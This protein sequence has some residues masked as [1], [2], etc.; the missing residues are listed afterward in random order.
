MNAT[1]KSAKELER[2]EKFRCMSAALDEAEKGV[3]H[4]R[5][6][7]PVGAVVVKNGRIIGRGYHAHCGEDHAEV[8]ALKSCK[9]SPKGATVYV[10]LEPCS[11]PGRV[12]ACTDALIAAGVKRVEWLCSDPNPTNHNCALKILRREG[13]ETEEWGNTCSRILNPLYWRGVDLLRPFAKVMMTGLPFV[14]V[15]I[16]MSLDGKICDDKGN[17]RWVSSELSRYKTARLR[18]TADCVLVGAETIRRDNPSLLCHTKDNPD[19]YRVVITHSGNLP[20]DAQIFTDEA[21]DR[22]MVIQLTKGQPLRDAM[23][24]LVA[25]GFQNILCEGGLNLAR[26]LADEDLV[27][28]WLT[29]LCPIVIGSKPITKPFE[30]GRLFESDIPCEQDKDFVPRDLILE[31]KYPRHKKSSQYYV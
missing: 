5:P 28:K 3:G 10:T 21:K 24:L 2:K 14:T 30:F 1:S 4:T 13:I 7:P 15:K 23:M 17:A 22:T 26:G 8:A 11:K 6:N 29:V 31:A 12:G 9:V 25:K 18:E 27:D 16:A 20:K 19:L